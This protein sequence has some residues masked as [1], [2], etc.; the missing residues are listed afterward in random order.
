[1]AGSGDSLAAEPNSRP[2][3]PRNYILLRRSHPVRSRLPREPGARTSAFATVGW[4]YSVVDLDRRCPVR[5]R[6]AAHSSPYDEI[7]A[8]INASRNPVL[9]IDIPSGLDCDTGEPL[10]PTVRATHT[11]TFVAH[12]KGF[13][14]PHRG[15]GPARFTSSTS[16]RRGCW[17]RNTSGGAVNLIHGR[18]PFLA[19]AKAKRAA[20]L[21]A[22]PA[23]RTSS[24]A[25]PATRSSPPRS[26]ARTPSSRSRSTPAT[27][28]TSPPPATT[29][30]RC[31]SSARAGSSSSRTPTRS[32]PSTAPHSNST[33][34]SQSPRASWFWN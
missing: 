7:V 20:G 21:R 28:S 19:A 15:N 17:S 1:M 33:R 23:T 32:S 5:H 24:S 27:S 25:S 9:A 10:G 6:L 11:A 18:P 34:P 2:T 31:R 4:R 30:K 14:N 26:A 13:L 8:R 12:K 22:R 16:A 29:S 3:R